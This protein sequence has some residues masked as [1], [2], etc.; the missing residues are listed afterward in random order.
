MTVLKVI[1]RIQ[2][3][4][5][6]GSLPMSDKERS[7]LMHLK[8]ASKVQVASVHD[9]ER[10]WLQNQE[11]QAQVNWAKT[12]TRNCSEQVRRRTPESPP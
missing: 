1:P 6:E 2:Q 5:Y 11:L 12:M 8:Q 9:L 4:Y 3:S 7:C 10:S